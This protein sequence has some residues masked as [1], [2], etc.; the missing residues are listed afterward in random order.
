M[1]YILYNNQA[2]ITKSNTLACGQAVIMEAEFSGLCEE[3]MVEFSDS[4][5]A[6]INYP[7]AKQATKKWKLSDINATFGIAVGNKKE[8]KRIHK[9][10]GKL[11]QKRRLTLKKGLESYEVER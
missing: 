4:P 6:E 8:V 11:L 3:K 9:F 7:Y 2:T 1:W 10:P 5:R